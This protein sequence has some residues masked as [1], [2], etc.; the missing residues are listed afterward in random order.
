MAGHG[1]GGTF[2]PARPYNP[3]MRLSSPS[4]YACLCAI[5]LAACGK[6]KT[7]ADAGDNGPD[8]A[9]TPDAGPDANPRGTVHVTVI[10]N[11]GTGAPVVNAPVVF[12]DPDGTMVA[13]VTTDGNGQAQADI[14]PGANATAIWTVDATHH[15]MGTIFGL[16]PGDD[17]TLGI[18]GQ[19][20]SAAGSFTVT[21]VP[22]YSGATTYT[23]YGPCG[24]ANVGAGAP[25]ATLSLRLDCKDVTDE[26]VVVAYDANNN[27]LA[28]INQ[29]GITFTSGGSVSVAGKVYATIRQFNASYTAIPASVASIDL[30]RDTAVAYGW[31][32]YASQQT[33]G[34]TLN[35][36]MKAP[37]SRDAWIDNQ[38]ADSMGDGN[39]EIRQKIAGNSFTYGMDV[40]NQLLPWFHSVTFDPAT[41]L[42]SWDGTAAP[43]ADFFL[44][45]VEYLR[46]D[47]QQNTS[48]FIWIFFAPPG[49]PNARMPSLPIDVG[50]VM[51]KAGD[52]IGFAACANFDADTIDGYD[53]IRSTVFPDINGLN[54]DPSIANLRISSVSVSP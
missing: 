19:D 42:M 23:V 27:P 37:V 31:A 35:L 48:T 14:L 20:S 28:S 51:P 2:G 12:F 4:L 8:A 38:F 47:A 25:V 50:D 30:G 52:A 15:Q 33:S 5:S 39:Q 10:D 7:F 41:A 54:R 9:A 11:N 1:P 26:V 16:K 34:A 32:A 18:R 40:G 22:S 24:S 45:E 44:G 46:T 6:V 21:G 43:S 13:D 17:V 53:E 36:S 29:T 49:I 3:D